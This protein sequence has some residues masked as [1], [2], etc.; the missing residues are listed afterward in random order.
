MCRTKSVGPL[1]AFLAYALLV[2]VAVAVLLAL[3]VVVVVGDAKAGNNKKPKCTG[4]WHQCRL[5]AF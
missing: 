2:V 3:V 4:D 1:K 5:A